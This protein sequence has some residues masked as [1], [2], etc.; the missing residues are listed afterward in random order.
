MADTVGSLVPVRSSELAVGKPLPQAIYDWHGN[1][2]LAAG[3]IIES[4]SQLEGLIENGF[5][6]DSAWDLSPKPARGP[7]LAAS[8]RRN[9]LAP[10][11]DPRP[12]EANSNKEIVVGMDDV[13]WYVGETLYLQQIDN[14]SIR[15]TVRL[16]GFVK[17]KTVM[18][19]AP[20]IDGKLEFV[21]D[22]QTF[23]VRAFVGKKAYAFVTSAVKSVH[24]P[25]P[26]LHLAFPKEVRCTV[27]RRGVRAQ[28]KVIA[29]VGLDN[30]ERV[31]AAVLT[32]LSMGG[33]SGTMK[34]IRGQK[35]EAGQIKFKVHAAEQEEVLNLKMVLRSI[36]PAEGGDGYRHGFEFLDVSVYDRLILS[37]FVH[38]ILAEGE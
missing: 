4:S 8:A 35:G 38:Q 33:A 25:H 9:S 16:I 14:P 18:I 11:S 2:L 26:Y 28:V 29:S 30:P 20:S 21:R 36:A 24:S 37:A 7:V 5:I 31:G 32:D 34:Q 15:Y 1:L 13:R 6:Q 10:D 23:I 22:G 19:T 12:S 27:V 3:C 17:N